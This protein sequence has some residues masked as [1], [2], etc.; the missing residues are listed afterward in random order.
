MLLPITSAL[1]VFAFHM[2]ALQLPDG[3][4]KV[5]IDSSFSKGDLNLLH[6]YLPGKTSSEIFFSLSVSS[7]NG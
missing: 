2:T 1:G 4:Y 3:K 5:V 7:L 6:A